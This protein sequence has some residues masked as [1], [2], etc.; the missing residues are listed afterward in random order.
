MKIQLYQCHHFETNEDY[1]GETDPDY[2]VFL[3]D[4]NK[5]SFEAD[6]F[7]N[8]TGEA[9]SQSGIYSYNSQIYVEGAP[10][11]GNYENNLF[12]NLYYGIY[13][14]ASN[15]NRFADIQAFEI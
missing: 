9:Q 1:I 11:G 3:N 13:A 7:T 4:I 10:E 12:T 8:N 5:V 14:M 6:E 2:F 15:P